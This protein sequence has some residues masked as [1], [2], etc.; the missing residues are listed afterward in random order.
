VHQVL[1]KHNAL[2]DRVVSAKEQSSKPKATMVFIKC[3]K[4]HIW[5]VAAT[6]LLLVPFETAAVEQSATG[7][8][9]SYL[10]DL[11]AIPKSCQ[12]CCSSHGGVSNSCGVGG[13]IRCNDGTTS[14]SCLCSSCGTA[15]PPPPVTSCTYTYGPWSECQSNSTQTRTVTSSS[16]SGC[17]GTPAVLQACTYVSPAPSS[18]LNYTSLWWNPVESGWGLNINHQD[19]I[20]FATLFTYS[21][22]GAPM[23]LVASDLARQSDDSYAGPLYRVSGPA[24]N[25]V[26]WS[27]VSV[28]QVGTM[29]IKFADENSGQLSYTVDSVSVSKPIEK[30]IFVSPT[31]CVGSSGSRSGATNYQDLWW[32]A[33]ESG[34]GLNLAHQGDVIFA[35]LFTYDSAGN[36]LWL[37]ASSMRMQYDG[38]FSGALFATSGRSFNAAPWVPIASVQVGNMTLRFENGNSATLIYSMNGVAVTKSIQRQVFGVTVPLCR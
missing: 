23:W 19:S 14:P 31:V 1:T 28:I 24:F 13:R 36:D 10:A 4:L 25:K 15:P 34:W 32:N 20:L 9:T 26:P 21:Q 30:L 18:I 29:R 17:S 11:G 38:S 33:Q 37:V 7:P 22:S 6:F 16:P 3:V 27:S 5:L 35:T 8:A 12:G 2:V